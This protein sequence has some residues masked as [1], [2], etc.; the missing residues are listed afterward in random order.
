MAKDP[1]P[2]MSKDI[3]GPDKITIASMVTANGT[4]AAAIGGIV[5]VVSHVREVSG[6]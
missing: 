2:A 4:A 1:D 6:H 5:N 3:D